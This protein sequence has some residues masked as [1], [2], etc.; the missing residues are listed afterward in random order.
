M[1]VREEGKGEDGYL[2]P[3]ARTNCW[4]AAG[5]SLILDCRQDF[6]LSPTPNL[7]PRIGFCRRARSQHSCMRGMLAH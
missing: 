2:P 5:S 7:T 3:T 1:S 6:V 4:L